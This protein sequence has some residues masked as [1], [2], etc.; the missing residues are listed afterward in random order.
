MTSE[1][2]K[3]QLIITSSS[4]SSIRLIRD[5]CGAKAACFLSIP[6]QDYTSVVVIFTTELQTLVYDVLPPT[7]VIADYAI[8]LEKMSAEEQVFVGAEMKVS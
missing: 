7:I 4:S 2:I 8:G 5:G 1:D 6:C 3:H